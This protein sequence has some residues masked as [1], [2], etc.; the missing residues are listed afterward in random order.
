M[1]KFDI[2]KMFE[3]RVHTVVTYLEAHNP[4]T[5]KVSAARKLGIAVGLSPPIAQAVIGH[6]V[7]MNMVEVV[8]ATSPHGK[9]QVI[10]K[11]TL[12][13]ET[14]WLDEKPDWEG[15]ICDFLREQ[16]PVVDAGGYA[17][18][19]LKERSKIP[20]STGHIRNLL[21]GLEDSDRIH[22]AI[23]GKRT[24]CVAL[25]EQPLFWPPGKNPNEPVVEVTVEQ[26]LPRRAT[27]S[28]V[29]DIEERRKR[30]RERKARV[31][32]ERRGE[33][34]PPIPKPVK[35]RTINPLSGVPR[36][37]LKGMTD[38]ELRA[39][40][41]QL[42]KLRKARKPERELQAALAAA[43]PEARAEVADAM[44]FIMGQIVDDVNET[45][46]VNVPDAD[47]NLDYNKLGRAMVEECGKILAGDSA[48]AEFQ[49]RLENAETE[50]VTLRQELTSTAEV[51]KL[52]RDELKSITR[53]ADDRGK[54][55]TA[56]EKQLAEAKA[57]L[58]K[59]STSA[60]IGPEEKKSIQ[61]FLRGLMRDDR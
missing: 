17:V 3:E 41:N 19:K 29:M 60:D 6:L 44:G 54:A 26:P 52:L 55:V 4:V 25:K 31:R 1:A 53:M 42:A 27:A 15:I 18:A 36:V 50:I 12:L 38:E 47:D 14:E 9:D 49:A 39:H 57:Q 23:Q 24:Y 45:F 5:D 11:I 13:P 56:L 22:R 7:G 61:G 32:A 35:Q 2:K 34:L 37:S 28:E 16:G 8:R 46:G 51:E 58:T 21:R 40:K 33:V 43:S 59:R 48:G 20:F 10:T 30:D